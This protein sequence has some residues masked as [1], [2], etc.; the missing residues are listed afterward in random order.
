MIPYHVQYSIRKLPPYKQVVMR[1]LSSSMNVRFQAL[2]ENR[3]LSR[4]DD[5]ILH[6]LAENTRLIAYDADESIILEGQPCQGLNIVESGR[7]K[8]YKY[9]ST[10][11]EMIINVLDEGESFNEVSVFDEQENPVNVSAVLSTRIWLIS[12]DALREVIAEHPQACQQ[13]II[14]LSQN[15]RML[16]SKVAELSFYTVTARLARLL[17]ELPE[18]QLSGSGSSRITQ[19]DMAA[20]IGTVREVVARSLKELERV[21]AIDIQRGRITIVNQEKLIDWE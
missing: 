2:Q 8:I 1:R 4:L 17:R 19:D 10:G 12:A 15:L 21:G 14:N 11:R 6:H 20:R 16:V 18:T 9:S 13:I 5:E 3:Y 7:V